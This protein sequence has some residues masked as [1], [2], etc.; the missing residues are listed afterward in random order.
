VLAV[1]RKE[2]AKQKKT[3]IRARKMET[4]LQ[5]PFTNYNMYLSVIWKRNYNCLLQ[6]T[7]VC[8]RNMETKLRRPV[9]ISTFV[10]ED[11]NEITKTF[12]KLHIG[13]S[14]CLLKLTQK[15]INQTVCSS[16]T[17]LK[18]NTSRC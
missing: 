14:K 4:K 6:I 16:G 7:C 3:Y 15:I 2:V 9:K 11:C 17:K 8:N 13:T 10:G 18:Q 5:R 12:S 1:C